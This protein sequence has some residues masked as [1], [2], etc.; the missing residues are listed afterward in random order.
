MKSFSL[1]FSIFLFSNIFGQ[2]K[3]NFTDTES[4]LK[5]IEPAKSVTSW[6]LISN[7]D[8][9]ENIIKSTKKIEDF[10]TQETGFQLINNDH[11]FYYIVFNE[12]NN[13]NYI[14]D[15]SSLKSFLGR[16]DNVEEAALLAISEGYF[17][18]I[19]FS[20]LAGN[21]IT[22]EDS[23]IVELAKITSNSCPLAKSH[24]E[25]TIDKK[26]GSVISVKDNGVYNEVYD[27]SCK[28]N[29]HYSAL[30]EQIDEAKE[31]KKQEAIESKEAKAKAKKKLMKSM[32]RR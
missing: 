11:Q 21:Y 19:E 26:S 27:K 14:T 5:G 8:G 25:L 23:Y 9:T 4:L 2:V 30:Q 15:L 10:S 31:K 20:D 3:T 1:F 12:G 29:P 13:V 16:I 18:D 24:F 22:T 6:M 7:E 17:L 28:N 32:R